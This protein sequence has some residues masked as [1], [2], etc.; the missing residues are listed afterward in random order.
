MAAFL[1]IYDRIADPA[2]K[3]DLAKSLGLDKLIPALKQA[4]LALAVYQERQKEVQ[5]AGLALSQSE[6][7]NLVGL[8]R[9]GPVDHRHRGHLHQDCGPDRAGDHGGAQRRCTRD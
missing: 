4:K 8:G 9:A 2:V 1:A 6:Q 7:D 5:R 3:A